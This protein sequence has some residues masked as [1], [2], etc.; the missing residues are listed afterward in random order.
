[1]ESLIGNAY[2]FVAIN[3][4]L[5]KLVEFVLNAKKNLNKRNV[6]DAEN[7]LPTRAGITTH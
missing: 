4:T 5:L 7:F 1:M 6:F 2:P 3:G